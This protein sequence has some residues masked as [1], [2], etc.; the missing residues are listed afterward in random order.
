MKPAVL[1]IAILALA[2]CG[3]TAEAPVSDTNAAAPATAANAAESIRARQSHYKDIGRAMKGI[4][5][6]LKKDAPDV[7]AI[8]AHAATIDRFAPQIQ[9]WFPDG[10]GAS[11]GV[12][13]AAR[14]EIWS[15]PDVFRSAAERLAAEAARF[16]VTT[17]SGDLAAIRAGVRD[18]GGACKNCHDSFRAEDD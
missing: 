1:S 18:L 3:D 11:A 9:G 8:Q 5:D 13:T 16:H 7:A 10:T 14:E 17:Q 6:E 15:K 4:N 12:K 2:A